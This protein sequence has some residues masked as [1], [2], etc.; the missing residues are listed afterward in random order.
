M[1]QA[2]L[3]PSFAHAAVAGAIS[4]YVPA[5]RWRA[6]RS[7]LREDLGCNGF[8]SRCGNDIEAF[9]SIDHDLVAGSV[10]LLPPVR[11]T[12]LVQPLRGS[13]MNGREGPNRAAKITARAVRA[14]GSAC[15]EAEP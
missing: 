4:C 5:T 11:P 8:R 14:S 15:S 2:S 7:T 9:D 3:Q 13:S 6:G 12:Q 1:G 10:W